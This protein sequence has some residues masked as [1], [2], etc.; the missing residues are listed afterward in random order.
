MS[1]K[2]RNHGVV[3]SIQVWVDR[4]VLQAAYI[5][6]SVHDKLLRGKEKMP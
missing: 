6:Y 2:A 3:T 1:C 5:E 4:E